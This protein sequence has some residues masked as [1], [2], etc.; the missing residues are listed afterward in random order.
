MQGGATHQPGAPQP[1]LAQVVIYL[2][3]RVA[4]TLALNV[5]IV[6]I[7]RTPANL[8]PLPHE[9]VSRSHA[10]LRAS[11][12]GVILTDTGSANGTFIRDVTLPPQ[13]TVQLANGTAS[14]IGT[15]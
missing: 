5:P 13:Q 15:F 9:S 4:R 2:E 11:P 10:E 12:E 14:R 8:L 1:G 6:T 7:G 3:G